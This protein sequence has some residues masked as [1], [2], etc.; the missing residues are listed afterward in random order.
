MKEQP[1]YGKAS[2][3]ALSYPLP[4]PLGIH[5][6]LFY[7][8]SCQLHSCAT[9]QLLIKNEKMIKNDEQSGDKTCTQ[10][11]AKRSKSGRETS[12]HRQT[13]LSCNE[14]TKKR[15]K[16]P[17]KHA[18]K[19]RLQNIKRGQATCSLPVDKRLLLLYNSLVSC[20]VAQLCNC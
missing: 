2:A 15:C 7:N 10:R 8:S 17:Q 5:L 9:V 4:I 20:I 12:K 19:I 14:A 13:R 16:T 6:P 3:I 1:R 18:I 11:A